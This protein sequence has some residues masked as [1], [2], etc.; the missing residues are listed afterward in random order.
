MA[1]GY[2]Q[3]W[4][5]KL[6]KCWNIELNH[7]LKPDNISP[8]SHRKVWWTCEKGHSWRAA[9]FSVVLNDCDCPYCTG[10]KAMP[11]ETDLVTLFPQLA[12]Q[13][14]VE[15][16]VDVDPR[17]VLPFSHEPVWWRCEL[18]HSWQ[19]MP[20]SR[21]GGKKSGCPYCSGKKVLPGFNDL[22]SLHPFVAREWY[23]PLNGELLPTMVSPGS[24]KKVW[25]RCSEQHVWEAAIYSRTR[26]TASGCPVCM[27]QAQRSRIYN[28]RPGRPPKELKIRNE[29]QVFQ[30]EAAAGGLS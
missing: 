19:A 3:K 26:K 6:S 13:W 15:K 21:T 12:K 29:K 28:V 9:V 1:E 4:N 11:G 27:G 2:D 25:W 14:D 22:A 8:G 18:G 30:P 23:Q 16:N 24:N 5:A 10:K 17:T 20:F 7:G